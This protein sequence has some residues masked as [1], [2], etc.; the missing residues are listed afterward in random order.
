M[1]PVNF[2]LIEELQMGLDRPLQLRILQKLKDKYQNSFNTFTELQEQF[3]RNS[4]LA[5]NLFY[6]IE[7]GLA[8]VDTNPVVING[9]TVGNRRENYKITAKGL[10]FLEDDGGLSAILNTVTVRFDEGQLRQ[11]IESKIALSDIPETDKTSILDRL[12]GFSGEAFKTA[13]S[14]LIELGIEKAVSDPAF[15]VR[16]LGGGA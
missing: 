9:I 12:K 13:V 15:I 14:K 1:N 5:F 10:D 4:G 11:I 2:I 7:H 8:Y 16:V 3:G 6:L